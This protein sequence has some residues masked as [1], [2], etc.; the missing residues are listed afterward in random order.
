M[1]QLVDG[2]AP[3]ALLRHRRDEAY[4]AWRYENRLSDYRFLFLGLEPC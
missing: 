2:V 1:A 4:L 3:E